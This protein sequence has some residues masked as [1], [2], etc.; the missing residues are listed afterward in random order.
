MLYALTLGAR[1][2]V[3]TTERDLTRIKK[4]VHEYALNAQCAGVH[5]AGSVAEMATDADIHIVLKDAGQMSDQGQ[6]GTRIDPLSVALKMSESLVGLTLAHSRVAYPSPQVRKAE[7]IA[8]I[9]PTV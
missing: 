3:L 8:A 6:V 9:S 1:F 5:L 2:S 7:L 4:M